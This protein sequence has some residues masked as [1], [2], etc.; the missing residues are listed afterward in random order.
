MAATLYVSSSDTYQSIQAA[1]DAALSGDEII[2]RD[3][4][5]TEN[6]IVHKS[7]TIR[8]ENGQLTTFIEATNPALNVVEI[9][10]NQVNIEGFSI[11][12]GNALNV[13]GILLGRTLADVGVAGCQI[14]HNR[15]GFDSSHKN[16]YGI[17]IFGGNNNT[18]LNNSVDFNDK[19]GITLNRAD[20]NNLTANSCSNNGLSNLYPVSPAGIFLFASNDNDINNCICNNNYSYGIQLYAPD[21]GSSCQENHLTDNIC[22]QNRLIG[23]YLDHADFNQLTDNQCHENGIT[24]IRLLTAHH[25]RLVKT[26][27]GNLLVGSPNGL[28]LYEANNNQITG[29]TFADN[30]FALELNAAND[31]YISGSIFTENSSSIRLFAGSGMSCSNNHLKN[32]DATGTSTAFYGISLNNAAGNMITDNRITAHNNGLYLSYASD[33]NLVINNDF[34]GNRNSAIYLRQADTNFIAKNSCSTDT[35]AINKWGLLLAESNGNIITANTFSTNYY[36]LHLSRTPE[37]PSSSNRIYANHFQENRYGIYI[38]ENCD[39]SSIYLNSMIDNLYF[40]AFSNGAENRW[41]SP[42]NLHYIYAG[43]PYDSL[44]G[45]YYDNHDLTDS[46]GNGITDSSYNLPGLLLPNQDDYPLAATPGTNIMFIDYDGD[47]DVDGLD[48]FCLAEYQESHNQ[49]SLLEF[50]E[51]FGR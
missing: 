30:D 17:Y 37:V 45:N 49:T 26:D 8:S 11:S 14:S 27:S 24:A 32:N 39:Q 2:V 46:N 36:G 44:T 35:S 34:Q 7:L 13:C 1:V 42:E 16:C 29:T 12:G 10:A 15:I 9:I 20:N 50:A 43:N 33:N 28:V 48:F 4:T 21:T 51:N 3:G 31:N 40:N 38:D 25:N 5:Y 47:R 23:I 22:D 41:F 19:F 18:L 6:I